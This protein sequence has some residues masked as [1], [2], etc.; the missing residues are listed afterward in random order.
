MRD[1]DVIILGGGIGGLAAAAALGGAGLKVLLVEQGAALGGGNRSHPLEGHFFDQGYHAL[2]YGRSL[3]VTRLLEKAL[4]GN[5]QVQPL[6][7]WIHLRGELIPYNAPLEDWPG[8]LREMITVGEDVASAGGP[9][10]RAEL[11]RRFGPAFSDFMAEEVLNS[12][13][14]QRW[15]RDQMGV[16]EK[17]LLGTVYPWF[18]PRSQST[19]SAQDESSSYHARM[20]Q[21]S[22]QVLYP[23]VG[24]FGAVA[25]G[26]EA[27]ARN[28]GVEIV[29]GP[30][31]FAMNFEGS[32]LRSVQA[33]G[34]RNARVYLW[35]AP[36]PPLMKNL[37]IPLPRLQGQ[38]FVFGHYV[39]EAPVPRDIHEILVG[40]KDLLIN[41]VSFPGKLAGD[42]APTLQLEFNF[43]AGE[44][45]RDEQYWRE[46]W[47]RDLSTMGLVEPAGVRRAHILATP[48]G[49]LMRDDAETV[50]RGLMDSLDRLGSNVRVP[51]PSFGPENI[52]RLLPG[53]ILGALAH[54]K[55]AM[56]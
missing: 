44:Y 22:Q 37:G 33:N 15:L 47:A 2:D 43:P 8:A 9:P 51:Y 23:R 17:A 6:C 28:A 7:R 20:R 10:D 21:G 36:L 16:P 27:L 50:K 30:S 53:N 3:L 40:S 38:D 46:R 41:R 19:A 4:A 18:F 49:F 42:D 26:L 13:P 45:P 5:A 32:Q 29:V 12:Y 11:A 55:E 39:L 24:G 34:T 31:D 1:H 35:C 54:T 14:S 52:N 48:R 56:L 25:T